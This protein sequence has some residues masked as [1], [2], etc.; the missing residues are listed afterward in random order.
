M[1][2]REQHTN[3]LSA[4]DILLNNQ[5]NIDAEELKVIPFEHVYDEDGYITNI[6]KRED[7]DIEYNAEIEKLIKRDK[8]VATERKKKKTSGHSIDAAIKEGADL[9][10]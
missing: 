9:E 7:I 5:Y 8:P 4:Y 3:Q 6:Q 10:R 2:K 1:S